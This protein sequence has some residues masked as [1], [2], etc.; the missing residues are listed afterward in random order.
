MS[1]S[2]AHVFIDWGAEAFCFEFARNR[3]TDEEEA[4]RV[5]CKMSARGIRRKKSSLSEVK[6]AVVGAPSVGKS[7]RILTEN[8][9]DKTFYN[10]LKVS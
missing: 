1:V 7:G 9:R 3:S 5:P 4:R 6:V 8:V 2:V 10:S